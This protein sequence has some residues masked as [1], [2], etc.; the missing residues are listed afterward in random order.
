M[1]AG[2]DASSSAYGCS[3]G[4]NNNSGMGKMS[5]K[6]AYDIFISYRRFVS[7]M[8]QLVS[9]GLVVLALITGCLIFTRVSFLE[10]GACQLSW[11]QS[12]GLLL[13]MNVFWFYV[14]GL[15]YAKSNRQFNDRVFK[16]LVTLIFLIIVIGLGYWMGAVTGSQTD[17]TLGDVF[18]DSLFYL[19]VLLTAGWF[20]Y[21]L[22][23]LVRARI[24]NAVLF[25]VLFVW[26]CVLYYC[27]PVDDS[28][29]SRVK[30][31]RQIEAPNR[32]VAAFFPSR[33]GFETVSRGKMDEK[34]G[35]TQAPNG[36]RSGTRLHYFAF[37]TLVIFYVALIGF[38]IFGRGIVNGVRK[39]FV[40]W[41]NLN[42]FWG[43]SNAGLL[44]ARDILK[45]T[46]DDQVVFM[47]QQQSGDSEEWR[48]Q[49]RDIDDMAALWMF[50]HGSNAVES[51]V[52]KDTLAQAKGRRHFFMAESG[53]VNLSQAD[54]LAKV[55]REKKPGRGLQGFY[56]AVSAGVFLWWGNAIVKWWGDVFKECWGKSKNHD[57][58]G[59]WLMVV[60]A[61]GLQSV[62]VKYKKMN[63]GSRHHRFFIVLH[64]CLAKSIKS[65]R[66]SLDFER[67]Y[68]YVRMD[69]SADEFVYLEWAANVR[70]VVRPIL[71]KESRLI[72]KE[73]IAAHPMLDAPGIEVDTGKAVV[74]K[75]EFRTLLIGFGAAGQDVLNE[76]VC[77]G[78]FLGANGE[79]VP[80]S[81]DIVEKD[82]KV[83]EEYSIRHPEVMGEYAVKFVKAEKDDEKSA[84]PWSCAKTGKYVRVED[85][86]FDKW[87][88]KRLTYYNRIII[89]LQGDEKTLSAAFKVVE[90]ARRFGVLIPPGIVFARVTDPARNRYVP[91]DQPKMHNLYTRGKPVD[92]SIT[93]FGDLKDIYSF[94]RI[95]A[96]TVD[97]MAKV[98]NSRKETLWREVADEQ[99]KEKAWDKASLFDQ[100]SSRASAEGQRNLLRLLGW[101][102]VRNHSGRRIVPND[103]VD[104]VVRDEKGVLLTLAKTEH[105]RWNA[106]HLMMGYRPWDVFKDGDARHDLPSMPEKFRAN[107]LAVIGKH[108][109]IVPFD[110]LPRVDKRIAEW[111]GDLGHVVD[112]FV[113]LKDGSSQAWDMVFCQMMGKVAESAGMKIVEAKHTHGVSLC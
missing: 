76:I 4:S 113:G 73:F 68:F 5:K 87:F 50:T 89:C 74:S 2:G 71:L 82:E 40:F 63:S 17:I 12:F 55:L 105:L 99:Q 98:L 101:E 11:K 56:A 84:A 96:E 44:L 62:F 65:F 64:Y 107:Q 14:L 33:G 1:P 111:N 21:L 20:F 41:K 60:A 92:V 37:H 75:G 103:E 57:W 80:F 28:A 59:L 30:V 88:K 53:H 102:C 81:V 15:I 46:D 48:T 54:R 13:L 77:N 32:T 90:F 23:P 7:I 42:V 24:L 109:D 110:E 10:V 104:R 18:V 16:G 34:K 58:R 78:Q 112:D 72:A 19:F 22:A 8:V 67:P 97:R 38:S 26:G 91:Y 45:I 39:W 43:R 47:L 3:S 100:L 69:T 27:F 25:M 85:A 49:T 61:R 6:K 108:A 93:L 52:S 31:E 66:K 106:F 95:D 79:P 94:D 70:D 29:S 51:D 35:G 9:V 83:I 86:S 36:D